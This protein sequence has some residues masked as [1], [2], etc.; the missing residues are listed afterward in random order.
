MVGFIPATAWGEDLEYPEVRNRCP[1][2]SPNPSLESEVHV[3]D[4]CAKLNLLDEVD[5]GYGFMARTGGRSCL[6][7][8]GAYGSG[9]EA[10]DTLGVHLD[11]EGLTLSYSINGEQMGSCF[12]GAWAKG[13]PLIPFIAMS[14]KGACV[15]LRTGPGVLFRPLAQSRLEELH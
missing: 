8:V 15:R 6:G 10:G 4:G 12:E 3:S 1:N 13:A 7:Q 11:C 9:L 2:P 14:K 5:G